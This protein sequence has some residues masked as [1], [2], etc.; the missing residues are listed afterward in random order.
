[1]IT[2]VN[3]SD[4]VIKEAEYIKHVNELLALKD[5]NCKLY[6]TS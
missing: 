6:A 1:M 4:K 2:L 3:A 5:Y